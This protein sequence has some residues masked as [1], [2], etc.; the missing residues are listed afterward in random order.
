[1][2][3]NK[4]CTLAN[5]ED[6]LHKLMKVVALVLMVLALFLL[7]KTYGVL[8]ENRFIG[9]D[10]YPQTTISVDAEGEVTAIPDIATF[11]FSVKEESKTVE[12]AQKTVNEKMDKAISFLKEQ[13][14]PEEN[15]KTTGYNIYPRY[16]WW[17]KEAVQCFTYPCPEPD[18][19]RKLVGYE[20]N[21]NISVKL[22]DIDK[23][24]DVL[25]GLGT[26]EVTNVSA[27][28]FE[29]DEKDE[30]I[31]QAR[32]IAIGK[33]QEKAK[34]LAK[35]LDVKLV[36]MV[37]YS[38][39]EGNDRPYYAKDERAYGMGGDGATPVM[40][41]IPVGENEIKVNVYMTYEIK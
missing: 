22:E 18:R 14:V 17:T 40:A 9:Q 13:G 4:N 38:S 27:L 33:A 39:N 21:Q 32:E 23:A 28:S 25:T 8:K 31:K 20:V 36:R 3:E 15:I 37:S 10:V 35:D 1:M 26:L 34:E 12:E 16:E 7:T 41:S 30:L 6:C 29:I 24:G 2:N 11:S 5:C 19:E